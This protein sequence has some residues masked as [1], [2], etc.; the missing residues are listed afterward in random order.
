MFSS[1]WNSRSSFKPLTYRKKWLAGRSSL[2]GRVV[3]RT[4]QSLL[5]RIKLL[6]INYNFRLLDPGFASTLK[7]VPFSNK[8]LV[9][10]HFPSGAASYFPATVSTKIFALLHFKRTRFTPKPFR[11]LE[12]HAPIYLAPLFKKVSNLELLPG[13][14]MQYARSEGSFATITRLNAQTHTAMVKLPSGVRK[15][16]SSYSILLL[17][18]SAL[19]LKRKLSNTRSGYWRSYGVKSQVR[20]VAMNPVD[21]PHG[22]RTKSIKY[23]RTPWGKTTKFK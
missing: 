15:L 9:L 12:H 1:K 2:T 10:A 14:G 23:P 21:H 4:K 20:G 8:L 13:K 5:R 19:K 17:G 7:L 22:G 3:V 16:F 6:R 11:G 18:P